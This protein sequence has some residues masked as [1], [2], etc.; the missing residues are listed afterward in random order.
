MA[1]EYSLKITMAFEDTD[2]TR[3]ITFSDLK[4]ALDPAETVDKIKAINSSLS[5]GTSDGL[6]TFFLS[7][8]GDK[9]SEIISAQLVEMTEVEIE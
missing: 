1:T 3:I 8:E 5:G 9:F 6:D 2:Q 4:E 7:D